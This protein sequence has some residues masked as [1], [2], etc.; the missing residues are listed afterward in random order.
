MNPDKMLHLDLKTLS[1]A[2]P[3]LVIDQNTAGPIQTKR[4]W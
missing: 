4:I 3:N 2:G 1:S